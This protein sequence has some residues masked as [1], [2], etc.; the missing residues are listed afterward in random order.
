MK[1]ISNLL[2]L[3]TVLSVAAI[4]QDLPK[5]DYKSLT[6]QM[7]LRDDIKH[8]KLDNGLE[9]FILKNDKPENRVSLRMPVKIGSVD[10]SEVQQGMAHFVEHM[11]F[12][13]TE[14]FPKNEL[15]NFLEK[16][17]VK[18]GAH[19]N[20]YTSFDETVYMLDLPS[21][22]QK[23][24]ETGV[25]ILEN[26]AHKVTFANE[27]IDDER[28]VIVEEARLRG[29][30]QM[31]LF[32]EHK[33]VSFYNSKY[34]N[35]LP[36]GDTTLLRQSPHEEFRRFY[37]KWY[38][39]DLMAV[40]V[41]GDIDVDQME[42]YIKK[43][44][45]KIKK[46]SNPPM[47]AK[48]DL[49]ENKEPLFSVATDK[50]LPFPTISITYRRPGSEVLSNHE[51]YRD[52]I[53]DQ[54]AIGA[55]NERLSEQRLTA[56][57][58]YQFSRAGY[59]ASMGAEDFS[60]MAVA[61]GTEYQKAMDVLLTETMRATKFGITDS[62]LERMKENVESN[63]KS[64]YSERANA[65][66]SDIG[67]ELVRHFLK[68]ESVPGIE[69]E[70]AFVKQQLPTITK[71]EV[72]KRLASYIDDNNYIATISLPAS[73]KNIPTAE[74]FQKEYETVMSK[75][76]TAKE[77][78][79][80]DKPLFDKDVT[81]GEITDREDLPKGVKKLVLSNGANVYYKNTDFKD[82]EIM[83]RAFSPGG[84]SVMKGEEYKSGRFA[85]EIINS[86]GISDFDLSTLMK[87]TS[88][89]NY[90]VSP[91]IGEMTEGF[92]G[93]SSVEDFE[94]MLQ[95]LHLYFTAPRVDEESFQSWLVKRKDALINSKRNPAS[96]LQDSLGYILSGYHERS[97]PTTVADLENVDMKAALNAYKKR[98]KQGGD[99][100]Y[101]F[102]GNIDDVKF[103]ELVKKYI[104]SLE[105]SGRTEQWKD[106]G[107]R[108]PDGEMKKVFNK[109][110]D[111][112][113]QVILVFTND[114]FEYNQEN[115]HL[116]KSLDKVF[117]IRLREQL[118]EVKGGVYNVSA[119]SN[120][121]KYPEEESYVVVA[122]G[123]DPNRVDELIG[124]VEM[125]AKELKTS[126]ISD[127]NMTKIKETQRREFEL[128]LKDNRTWNT[129]MYNSVWYD[130][131]LKDVDN[132]LDVVDELDKNEIK[133]AA[134]KYLDF[135]NLKTFILMP[136]K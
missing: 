97:K 87:M 107:A 84:T 110:M 21:D 122:F 121:N 33:D 48:Y 58:A 136:E 92:R 77:E 123:C 127:E 105:G 78:E 23:V 20:A 55:L 31:R 49:P 29:G 95:L 98:F 116:M 7:P 102:T 1:F 67:M 4:S 71:A 115:K 52:V 93:N 11:C 44:F 64:S 119:Y 88:S 68:D 120:Y 3:I 132:Y 19:L 32:D 101:F 36:I 106:L 2:I 117:G 79:S 40:I 81:P 89:K 5:M 75:E 70:Y 18:F 30:V 108:T 45:G 24:L 134:N 66:S 80:T 109:G 96:V 124:D 16:S 111:Q 46:P 14:D 130:E 99:F 90:N 114:D 56:D 38:R 39:P 26:W 118:R 103:E 94:E 61:K 112:K 27:D 76:I 100:D 51:E 6:E 17:G 13:G 57:P 62:E 104:G 59:G 91:T 129:W 128:A 37:K 42:S 131:D 133:D 86:S 41:V 47:P 82:D 72:N 8:G 63:Y 35:R 22:D 135:D 85:G 28:G 34:E 12:N 50:E 65:K 125:I 9:Y 53:I 54:L 126:L 73:A 60:L 83:F 15:I 25:Q 10:E 74:Q 43:Y 113:S 69:Y